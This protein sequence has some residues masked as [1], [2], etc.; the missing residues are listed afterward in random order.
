MNISIEDRPALLPSAPSL[1][2]MLNNFVLSKK[3]TKEM[4]LVKNYLLNNN[5]AKLTEIAAN[6]SN[7]GVQCLLLGDWEYL[8]PLVHNPNLHKKVLLFI[9]EY[10][11]NNG[12]YLVSQDLLFNPVLLK[13]AATFNKAMVIYHDRHKRQYSGSGFTFSSDIADT[14]AG[15]LQEYPIANVNKA[16]GMDMSTLLLCFSYIAQNKDHSYFRNLYLRVESFSKS[17]KM[18]IDS[19]VKEN[20]SDFE[21]MPLSWVLKNYDLYI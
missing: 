9:S 18:L 5:K 6:T 3:E 19:W 12:H 20:M 14:L 10:A 8:R 11:D 1:Q 15:L 21:G 16:N 13:D 4:E 17:H 2:D 7:A